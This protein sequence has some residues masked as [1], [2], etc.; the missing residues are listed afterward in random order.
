MQARVGD[1]RQEVGG[2]GGRESGGRLRDQVAVPSWR[3][4]RE[5]ENG[6][7]LPLDAIAASIVARA[8]KRR[9]RVRAGR[10]AC[11]L[12]MLPV[13]A[14]DG[15]M[16]GGF[17]SGHRHSLHAAPDAPIQHEGEEER[18]EH[19]RAAAAGA[20]H[21]FTL[22]NLGAYGNYIRA[23]RVARG[24]TSAERAHHD[25]RPRGHDDLP[26]R[27]ETGAQRELK[28]PPTHPVSPAP[29]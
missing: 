9:G 8:R 3:L 16:L 5:D 26:Q 23:V 1:H 27:M 17:G 6:L 7:M 12:R 2:E 18:C 28:E 10:R 22:W 14:L 24:L 20:L 4:A 25:V 21:A 29:D 19:T 15:G 11:V 13:D